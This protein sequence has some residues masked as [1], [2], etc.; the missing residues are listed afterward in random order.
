MITVKQRKNP[1]VRNYK[2]ESGTEIIERKSMKL[3]ATNENMKL[4]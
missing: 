4:S 3:G 2:T 1:S